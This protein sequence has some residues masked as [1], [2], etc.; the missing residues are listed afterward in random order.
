ME[1][2]QPYNKTTLQLISDTEEYQFD[3]NDLINGVIKLSVFSDIGSYLDGEDLQ[4]V[5]I[6][7]YLVASPMPPTPC[8]LGFALMFSCRSK[9][10]PLASSSREPLL[11]LSSSFGTLLEMGDGHW[12]TCIH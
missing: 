3:S 2:L 1:I 8:C 10:V 12:D 5:S 9:L 7:D 11:D 6:L 4:S